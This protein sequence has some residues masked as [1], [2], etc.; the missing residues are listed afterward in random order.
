MNS[1]NIYHLKFIILNSFSALKS[2][3]AVSGAYG[4]FS[5][6]NLSCNEICR[7]SLGLDLSV[8]SVGNKKREEE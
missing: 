3:L 1:S 2:L 8:C 4:T 5:T 6:K 7:S